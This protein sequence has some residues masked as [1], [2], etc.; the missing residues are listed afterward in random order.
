MKRALLLLT[1]ACALTVYPCCYSSDREATRT[2]YK[3]DAKGLEKQF[4]PFL[5]AYQKADEQAQTNAFRVF[6]FSDAKAW[7]REYFRPGN[8]QQL[9]WDVEAKT[10][11]EGY[12]NGAYRLVGGGAFPFWCMPDANDPAKKQ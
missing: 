4:E 3:Q 5:R 7:F 6:P 8:V 12:G 2:A 9:V 10:E 1:A 11:R